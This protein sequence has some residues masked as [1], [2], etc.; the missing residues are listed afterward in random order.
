MGDNGAMG[1]N[2]PTKRPVDMHCHLGFVADADVVRRC[3]VGEGPA[4]L[5]CTVSPADFE[6]DAA[7]FAA[8]PRCQVALGAHPWRIADGS[9]GEAELQRFETLAPDT[10]F[11]GEIGLDFAGG[12]GSA[13]SRA[14][15]RA[16]FGRMLDACDA[17]ERTD[18]APKLLSLHAV[19]ASSEVLDALEARSMPEHHHCVFHWFSGDAAELK[20]AIGLGCC[21]SVGPRML[22]TR[23]G[24]AHV[25]A[26][27]IERLL[28]ET[29][30]PAQLH[31]AWDC[32]SWIA[33]LQDALAD[34][35]ELKRIAPEELA[36]AIGAASE[37]LLMR[38]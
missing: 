26:I 8:L 27:P 28:L 9:I 24:R 35:A 7:R 15:Q 32:A 29:D 10:A 33:Q 1:T 18:T 37:R 20:R 34:I 17:P 19:R 13:E 16:A 3:L 30:A 31:D 38:G 36:S 2:E 12:R 22:A 5:S 23:R 6:R 21:F 25:R 14:V 11:I 4:A